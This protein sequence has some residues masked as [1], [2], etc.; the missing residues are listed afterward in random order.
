[1]V[2]VVIRACIFVTLLAICS[3]AQTNNILNAAEQ[4][5]LNDM[6]TAFGSSGMPPGFLNC[7]NVS[8]VC[9]RNISALHCSGSFTSMD[10]IIMDGQNGQYFRGT[11]PATFGNFFGLKFLQIK[12]TGITNMP[13]IGKMKQ[14]IFLSI[15]SSPMTGTLDGAAFVNLT[16]LIS[17][18]ILNTSLSGTIPGS[19]FTG[20][21]SI[22]I[23]QIQNNLFTDLQALT[24]PSHANQVYLKN[25][26]IGGTVP[27]SFSQLV[28]V[29]VLDLSRNLLT[30][31]G[32]LSMPNVLSLLLA[33]NLI[34]AQLPTFT[35]FT[36]MTK[37]DLNNNSITGTFPPALGT[38]AKLA[39]LDLTGSHLSGTLPSLAAAAALRVILMDGN[40]FC[41]CFP[42][43]AVVASGGNCNLAGSTF[44]CSNNA[45]NVCA[46]A[47][48][49]DP[50]CGSCASS[51]CTSCAA[52]TCTY[53]PN[54]LP[55]QP[56]PPTP[57]GPQPTF[58]PRTPT[59]TYGPPKTPATL[60]AP[61]LH[62]IV[63]ALAFICMA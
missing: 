47:W 43:G 35:G 20:S 5:A 28:N 55:P 22:S 58:P 16:S 17:I 4:Q 9:D 34:T 33:N 27:A 54:K 23:V 50:T 57:T 40:Q 56:N 36:S 18:Y 1:M 45:P 42:S 15:D 44:C 62:L 6:C 49:C 38:Y 53:D 37:L 63:A 39:Y 8:D 25:N 48:A 31:V 46:D 10:D 12:N 51:N 41:G 11:L 26:Q 29:T 19:V 52:V 13:A 3:N 32:T 2:A 24:K 21:P 60:L 14:L 7:A 30:G 59:P 61:V